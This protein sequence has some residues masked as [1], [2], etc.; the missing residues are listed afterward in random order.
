MTAPHEVPEQ[1]FPLQPTA[2]QDTLLHLH[3]LQQQLAACSAA[4]APSQSAAAA[5]VLTPALPKLYS[6][7]EE[8]YR[9]MPGH[10]KQQ[11]QSQQ[12]EAGLD[13]ASIMQEALR[14]WYLCSCA[15]Q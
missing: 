11:Q 10:S 7:L 8:T 1:A 5:A 12:K 15:L 9:T 6:L 3:A 4:A 13:V 14:E 2:Q